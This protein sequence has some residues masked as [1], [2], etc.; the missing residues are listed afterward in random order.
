M[1]STP[2]VVITGQV[3]TGSIGSDAFQE[4][5]ITGITS[6][7]TK[8]NFLVKSAAEL[9]RA[10]AAAFHLATTGRPGPVLVDVP[11]DVSQS[12]MEWWWP[13][14]IED[15]DLP[16]YHP[17]VELDDDAVAAAIALIEVAQRPVLYVG[18]GTLKSR[19]SKELLAFAERTNMPVVTT[20]MARGAFPDSHARH[21][22]FLHRRHRHAKKRPID[23]SRGEV[24]RP[25]DGT[26]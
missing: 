1:D 2:L 3:P 8:H 14:G 5:D 19:A 16:G 25:R 12:K 17:D 22:R 23:F 11:K 13:S 24:R 4:C 26:S 20:L 7:I 9:P 18:G 10:I 21:A 15:L 6:G